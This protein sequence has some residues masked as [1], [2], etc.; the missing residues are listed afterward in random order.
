MLL[1]RPDVL[2]NSRLA[3]GGTALIE[4][5]KHRHANVVEELLKHPNIE[6]NIEDQYGCSA[7]SWAMMLNLWK[8]NTNKEQI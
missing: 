6:V 5:A 1:E 8:E 3:N 7:L 2:I 4:A